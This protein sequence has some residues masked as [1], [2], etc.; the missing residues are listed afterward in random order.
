MVRNIVVLFL[1]ILAIAFA[2]YT[3]LNPANTPTLV[4]AIA[5][6]IACAWE[7]PRI[8]RKISSARRKN[9]NEGNQEKRGYTTSAHL[10]K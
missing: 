4:F 6:L 5:T 3:I 8:I 10:K 9:D 2:F 1:M 7:L